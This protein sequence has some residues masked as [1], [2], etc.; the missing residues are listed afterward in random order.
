MSPSD[1]PKLWAEPPKIGHIFRH[2]VFEN[3]NFMLLYFLKLS[4]ALIII[5]VSLTMT[6]FSEKMLIATR[7]IHGFMSNLIKKSWTDSIKDLFNY[8]LLITFFSFFKDEP[9]V[10]L[11]FGS[12]LNPDNLAEGND[13]YFECKIKA[14]PEVYKVVWLHDVSCIFH[15]WPVLILKLLKIWTGKVKWNPTIFNIIRWVNGTKI[16]SGFL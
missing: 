7:C 3:F 2:K 11:S 12:N 14:N 13:V 4:P 8:I 9:V 15:S 16:D 5:L 6:R 10:V 1:L